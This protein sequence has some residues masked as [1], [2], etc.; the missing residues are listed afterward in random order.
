MAAISVRL[1]EDIET[2]LNHEAELEGKPR[3]EV[4]R[5]AI[6]AYLA[7]RERE[8]RMA[9]M[10]AA[11]EALAADPAAM[12]ESLEIAN[13]LAEE[14]L[15]SVMETEKVADIDHNQNWWK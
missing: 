4:A 15:D 5:E 3:S 6:S 13:D 2:Q 14:G 9:E 7:Q 12:D 10:V 1:P 11:A 8:R